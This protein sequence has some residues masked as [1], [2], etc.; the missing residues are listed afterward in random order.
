MRSRKH[1]VPGLTALLF[2]S[3]AVAVNAAEEPSF[4]DLFGMNE[5]QSAEVLGVAATRCLADAREDF[6]LALSGQNPK[7]SKNPAFPQLLD[8]GTTFWEGACYKLTL[9][10][11]LTTYRLADGTLVSGFI[12]G[13]SLQLQ[14][15]PVASKA[16]PI[17]RTRFLFIEKRAAT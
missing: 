12:V 8:G 14:F 3:I 16:E 13:P 5:S 1:L 10:R 17:A 2:T 4:E 15:S 7:H 6:T 9:L 11:R